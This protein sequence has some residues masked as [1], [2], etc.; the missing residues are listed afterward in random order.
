[1]SNAVRIG[2]AAGLRDEEKDES[3]GS[4]GDITKRQM[5]RLVKRGIVQIFPTRFLGYHN[6]YGKII[7]LDFTIKTSIF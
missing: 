2:C 7:T 6:Q 5:S 4:A 3:S 1:M